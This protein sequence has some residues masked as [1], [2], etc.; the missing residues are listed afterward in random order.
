MSTN[1]TGVEL[2][3]AQP[4][5]GAEVNDLR[6]DLPLLRLEPVELTPP[7]EG[8]QVLG[9]ERADRAAALGS[10]DP[11]MAIDVVGDGDS[12]VLHEIQG[13]TVSQLL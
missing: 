3:A 13:I 8:A 6:L 2:V 12:D 1:R 4:I 5:T 10:A 7:G 9:D 11:G